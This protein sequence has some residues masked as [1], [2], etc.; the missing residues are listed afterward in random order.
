MTSLRAILSVAIPAILLLADA[1]TAPASTLDGKCCRWADH[2]NSY[3]YRAA[4]MKAQTPCTCSGYGSLCLWYSDEHGYGA[5]GK[6][7]CRVAGAV[8]AHR[9]LCRPL[10]RP[11][12]PRDAE[13][14]TPANLLPLRS[15]SGPDAGWIESET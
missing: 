3:R 12:F 10:Q 1:S 9:C 14:L 7:I 13:E 6:N 8:S 2:G 5:Y 15:A 11:A 4:V